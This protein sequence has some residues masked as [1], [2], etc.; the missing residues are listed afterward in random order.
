MKEQANEG[1]WNEVRTLVAAFLAGD[2]APL[3]AAVALNAYGHDDHP[4]EMDDPFSTF[5][6]IT[7]E[8][9]AIPLGNQRNLWH[10]DVRVAEDV[11][12]DRAQEWAR[13]LVETACRQ[14]LAALPET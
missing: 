2:L 4:V 3:E 9:D 13:P 1:R 5:V 8:T 12:H 11:K 14:I 6:L 7:S 10:P